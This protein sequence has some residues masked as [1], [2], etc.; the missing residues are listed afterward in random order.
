ISIVAD[1][2]DEE[3]AVSTLVELIESNFSE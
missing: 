2:S 3:E 1:G